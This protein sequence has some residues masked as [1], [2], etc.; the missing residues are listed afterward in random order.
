MVAANGVNRIIAL[1]GRRGAGTFGGAPRAGVGKRPYTANNRYR[2]GR[3]VGGLETVHGRGCNCPLERRPKVLAL[4]DRRHAAVV[5]DST[6][7]DA[8]ECST[9]VGG[10]TSLETITCASRRAPRDDDDDDYAHAA[11]RALSNWR[12]RDPVCHYTP[13][14]RTGEY[15][16]ESVF[17]FAHGRTRY[18]CLESL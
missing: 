2:G 8:R 16:Y 17:V 18:T 11:R 9:R 14:R 5:S 7:R 4:S 6:H 3:L 1:N 13:C 12:L 10:S 15:A